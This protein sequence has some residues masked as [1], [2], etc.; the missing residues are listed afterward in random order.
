MENF[1]DTTLFLSEEKLPKG[2]PFTTPD[3]YF[4]TLRE[5]TEREIAV[6]G[7]LNKNNPNPFVVEENYFDNLTHHI[8]NKIAQKK[9]ETSIDQAFFD[10]QR[11]TIINTISIKQ[12]TATKNP[13][14]IPAD[15]FNNL[16]SAIESKTSFIIKP[17]TPKF[18]INRWA[19]AAAAALIMGISI[20]YFIFSKPLESQSVAN[21]NTDSFSTAEI[22]SVLTKSEISE[23][24][25]MTH[26]DVKELPQHLS[27]EGKDLENILDE[28]DESDLMN[29]M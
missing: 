4:E 1:D 3:S 2:V 14:D 9:L 6:Q 28:L 13:F 18:Y 10:Q 24:E 12:K 22:V 20:G 11:D 21:F 19:Y 29:E 15:Y 16:T 8:E 25:L 27:M 5:T 23:E 26:I 17:T 7:Y